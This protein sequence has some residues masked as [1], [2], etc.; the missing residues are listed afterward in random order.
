MANNYIWLLPMEKSASGRQ[1]QCPSL[2]H[3][4]LKCFQLVSFAA[5]KDDDEDEG[6]LAQ[7]NP[8]PISLSLSFWRCHCSIHTLAS[9]LF[10]LKLSSDNCCLFLLCTHSD[11][12]VLF[13]SQSP[14]MA[15]FNWL[16]PGHNSSNRRAQTV[17]LMTAVFWSVG[18]FNNFN[19]YVYR[20]AV[21]LIKASPRIARWLLQ[22]LTDTDCSLCRQFD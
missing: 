17:C 16:S 15:T 9:H 6:T 5:T 21:V 18:A 13:I 22:A 14:L 1:L 11:F 2:Y 7:T 19:N 12:V 3:F 20:I 4:H 8:L 10:M